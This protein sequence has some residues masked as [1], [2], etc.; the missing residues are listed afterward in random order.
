MIG[1]LGIAVLLGLAFVLSEDRAAI[2][3]RTVVGGLGLQLALAL[4]LIDFPPARRP[5][6]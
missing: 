5:A 6:R 4:L 1:L 3:L 2:R